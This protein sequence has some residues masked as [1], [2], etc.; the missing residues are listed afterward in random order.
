MTNNL[1]NIAD[2][3]FAVT[4]PPLFNLLIINRLIFY[5]LVQSIASSWFVVVSAGKI[6]RF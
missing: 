6:S 3:A 2:C 1:P 4:P 5:G